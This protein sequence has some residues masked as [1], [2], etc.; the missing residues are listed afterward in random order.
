METFHEHINFF[1]AIVSLDY[2]NCIDKIYELGKIDRCE[3]EEYLISRLSI[4][5]TLYIN[6]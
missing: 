5:F 3:P 4:T 6:F 2:R 1:S